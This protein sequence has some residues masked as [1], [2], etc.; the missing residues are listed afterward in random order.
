MKNKPHQGKIL[1]DYLHT[2]GVKVGE[3]AHAVGCTRQSA[4]RWFNQEELDN[5]VKKRLFGHFGINTRLFE[6][7]KL[8]TQS[9]LNEIKADIRKMKRT[10]DQLL[11]IINKANLV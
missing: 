5:K 9:E 4:H 11:K 10:M 8:P 1:S 3:F 2:K 6:P 7:D